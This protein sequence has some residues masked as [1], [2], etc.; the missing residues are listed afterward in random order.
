MNESNQHNPTSSTSNPLDGMV[1]IAV[2]VRLSDLSEIRGELSLTVE[3]RD[4]TE[5]DVA[6][7]TVARYQKTIIARSHSEYTAL[8]DVPAAAFDRRRLNVW[9]HLSQKKGVPKVKIDD[10]VTTR[11]YP[12]RPTGRRVDLTVELHRVAQ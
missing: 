2:T 3:I 7:T 12:V 11:A 9:A 5:L 6:S 1:Q 4:V 10:Y 8:I